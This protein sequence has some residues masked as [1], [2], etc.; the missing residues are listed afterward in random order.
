MLRKDL[1]IY[2]FSYNRGQFLENC[3]NSIAACA[4]QYPVFLVDDNSDDEVT[5]EIIENFQDRVEQLSPKNGEIEHK[6]GGLYAN[7]KQAL[8]HAKDARYQFALFIQDD[9]QLVRAITDTDI[10]HVEN[11]FASQN[12]SAQLQT[13]FMKRYLLER[14]TKHTA[15]NSNQTAYIRNTNFQGFTGFSAVGLFKPQKF[16]ELFGDLKQGEYSNNHYARE[17]D[18]AMGWSTRPFMM[19]LPYPISHRGKQRNIPLQVIESVGGCGYY[20]YSIMSKEKAANLLKDGKSNFPFA[21]DW[22]EPTNL[23]KVSVWSFAGGISNLR[24]RGGLRGM[25]A[26]LLDK[27]RGL[28]NA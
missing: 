26:M 6:T 17:N 2:V 1:A 8:F 25:F 7:M 4:S 10:K 16:F 3:L 9:M 27:I 15:L 12:N 28:E 11:Y 5:L 21:E 22:L 19:W 20:P 13:C 18:I 23:G 24:A 14:D